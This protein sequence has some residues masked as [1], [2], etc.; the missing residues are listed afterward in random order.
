MGILA[1]IAELRRRVMICACAFLVLFVVGFWA[2]RPVVGWIEQSASQLGVSLHVF[3]VADALSILVQSAFWLALVLTAPLVLY[4]LWQFVKPALYPT[5][6]R[7]TLM[8]IPGIFGLFVLGA[9]F[10]YEVVFPT[11]LQFMFGL[12]AELDLQPVI[13]I[14]EYFDFLLRLVIPFGVLFELPLLLMLLTRLGIVSP[15]WLRQ[16]R[17]YAYF[18]LLVAAGFIAPPDALSLLIVTLPLIVL[19]EA[20]IWISAVS[21]VKMNRTLA[22]GKKAEKGS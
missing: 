11:V 21:T 1:H 20:G 22:A 13:G 6:R 4:Q 19:Y 17:K 5:E 18:I 7:A 3:R 12:S 16:S 14:R 9:A 2:A 8:Y 10:A 15:S